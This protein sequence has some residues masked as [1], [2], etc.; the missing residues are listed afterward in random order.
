MTEAMDQAFAGVRAHRVRERLAQE[1]AGQRFEADQ[2]IAN[3]LEAAVATLMRE[4]LGITDPKDA[5]SVMAAAAERLAASA[6]LYRAL[7][8]TRM[9]DEIE[10]VDFLDSLREDMEAASGAWLDIRA[11]EVRLSADTAA[12]IGLVVSEMAAIAVRYG[13]ASRPGQVSLL[14]PVLT[15]EADTNGLGETRL[16]LYDNGSDYPEGFDLKADGG[17]GMSIISGIVERLGGYVYAISRFGDY[18]RAGAGLEIVLP[19]PYPRAA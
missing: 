2:W 14:P 7:C 19:S 17:I 10:F 5:Q 18:L 13:H 8:R 9:R 15:V 4:R 12:R 16:R 1:A 3:S 6:R 11:G